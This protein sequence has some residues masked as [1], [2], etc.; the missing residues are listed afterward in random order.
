MTSEIK[1]PNYKGKQ[2][3][4]WVGNPVVFRFLVSGAVCLM[5]LSLLQGIIGELRSG[6][7]LG[8]L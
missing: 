2:K 3:V 1:N 4:P 6:S 8:K 5:E 7:S